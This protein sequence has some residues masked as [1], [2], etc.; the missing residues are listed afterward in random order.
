[1]G[2]VEIVKVTERANHDMKKG[3]GMNEVSAKMDLLV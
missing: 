2:N 3:R 1:M